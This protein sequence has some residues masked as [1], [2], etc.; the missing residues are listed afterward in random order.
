MGL[1]F[2]QVYRIGITHR[3]YTLPD[4]GLSLGMIIRYIPNITGAFEEWL[5][6]LILMVV[7]RN[8]VDE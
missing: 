8:V 2:S 4:F 5:L 3:L 1:F 6:D 7:I